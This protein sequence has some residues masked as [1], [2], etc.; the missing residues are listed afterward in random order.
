MEQNLAVI[1]EEL[2]LL[3][4]KFHE[5]CLEHDIKYSLHGGSLL[6]AVR[7]KGFI[8]WDDDADVSLTRS[9]FERLRKVLRETDLGP[10]F[11]YDEEARFTKFVMKR[12]GK[13][14][15]W[16]D[17]FIYDYISPKPIARKLKLMSNRFFIMFTRT[18]E[19]QALS[20][21]HG[22]YKGLKKFALN[23]VVWV[24]NLF[25]MSWRLKWATANM[26]SFPGDRS[27]IHRANDQNEGIHKTTPTYTMEEYETI[28]FLG[29]EVMIMKHHHE[30]LTS[31]YGPDYMT[32]RKM[33]PDAIHV[34]S[35]EAE[36]NKYIKE[37]EKKRKRRIQ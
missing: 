36:Q 33:K 32:P 5:L 15:V 18:K 23:A 13:P 20:N 19:E 1:H 31:C 14:P 3:M 37:F 11:Y 7:E 17:I 29:I 16:A 12:E 27:L 22:L 28:P 2:L 24:G 26:Q 34:L 25:P 9:E 10:E 30:I 4:K 21:H 35:L 6:G 8:P